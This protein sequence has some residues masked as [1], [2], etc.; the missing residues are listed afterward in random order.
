MRYFILLISFL[1]VATTLAAQIKGALIAKKGNHE[2]RFEIGESVKLEW[3]ENDK[4]IYYR[5]PILAVTDSTVV[6]GRFS[7]TDKRHVDIHLRN[8]VKVKRIRRTG[9]AITAGIMVASLIPGALLI[10]DA[11]S[12][13]QSSFTGNGYAIGGA[14][15]GGGLMTYIIGTMTEKSASID[16]GYTFVTKSSHE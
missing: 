2:K 6:L 5:G 14:L 12:P 1:F 4:G 7:S 9:R 15:I 10:A 11:S 3:E 16:R 8:I 13:Q